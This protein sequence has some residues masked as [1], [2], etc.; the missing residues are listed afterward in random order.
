MATLQEL[1][2]EATELGIEFSANIGAAKLA[3][4]IESF[5]SSQENSEKEIQEAEVAARAL[6]LEAEE[7]SEVKPAVS[8]NVSMSRHQRAKLAEEK[9]RKTRIVTITD[10]DT[11]ENNQTTVA[12][13]NCTNMY[14]D[15]GTAYIPLNVPIEVRQGHIDILNGV[16]IPLHVKQKDGLFKYEMRKRY[17]IHFEDVE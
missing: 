15:L 12:V 1:K 2:Q 8:N 13:A 17:S 5:Y 4:K 14:F 10:N 9:A 6:E 3:E 11:R 7:K 16:E